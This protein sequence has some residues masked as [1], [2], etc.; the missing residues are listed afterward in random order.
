MSKL[1]SFVNFYLSDIQRGLQTAHVVNEFAKKYSIWANRESVSEV[2][3]YVDWATLGQTLVL[4]NGGNHEDLLTKWMMFDN[5][6]NRYPW[7]YFR[8]DQSLNRSLT[9]VGIIL[10][11]K[12]DPE[13]RQ[14]RIDAVKNCQPTP[15]MVMDAQLAELLINSKPA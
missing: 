13:F 5:K 11:E 14:D 4:L 7:S 1:Y 2:S 15:R 9:A 12:F 10:P 6:R 8:E 3:Q